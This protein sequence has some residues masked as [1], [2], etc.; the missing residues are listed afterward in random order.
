M[1]S[2]EATNPLTRSE[3]VYK[4]QMIT[5]ML[6]NSIRSIRDGNWNEGTRDAW[7][8][9]ADLDPLLSHLDEA[10]EHYPEVR[11]NVVEEQREINRRVG[12]MGYRG[13]SNTKSNPTPRTSTAPPKP[14][15]VSKPIITP[16]PPI[17]IIT[18][19]P[20][21]VEVLE[22][23]PMPEEETLTNEAVE[24]LIF[25]R[26]QLATVRD[27]LTE[28]L[29]KA[30]QEFNNVRARL[31]REKTELLQFAVMDKVK[32]LLPVLDDFERATAVETADN[33]YAQ[34]VK[35]IHSRFASMLQK[36][37]VEILATVG[38][39][40]D[41]NLHQA[42]SKEESTEILEEADHSIIKEYQKG[43]TFQGKLLRP[44]MVRVLVYKPK[45][46]EEQ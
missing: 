11:V 29:K 28:R 23:E 25:E 18:P 35:Q 2:P 16:P 41:P 19:P 37:G 44:A 45:L 15:I 43:Y 40:F 10:C 32:E 21:P 30:Y 6:N 4:L 1:S 46:Q 26:D 5:A 9:Y 13:S 12:G 34:G 7:L 17:P 38:E 20:A 3:A 33:V 39:K 31:E 36:F 27:D 14:I 8:A 24:A 22:A 42:L